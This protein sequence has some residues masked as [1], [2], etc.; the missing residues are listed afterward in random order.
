MSNK[1]SEIKNSIPPQSPFD[2]DK[3]FQSMVDNSVLFKDP[4]KIEEIRQN[5][6]L[7]KDKL[8]KEMMNAHRYVMSARKNK[9]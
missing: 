6:Q 3:M 1:N 4:A 7:N 9:M 5:L 2:A 8:K